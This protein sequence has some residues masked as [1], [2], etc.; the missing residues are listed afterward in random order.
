MRSIARLIV[1]KMAT[2]DTR[3]TLRLADRS[4]AVA[5]QAHLHD[6]GGAVFALDLVGGGDLSLAPH[7]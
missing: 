6:G 5:F 1:L 2:P 4:Q 7:P 3:R